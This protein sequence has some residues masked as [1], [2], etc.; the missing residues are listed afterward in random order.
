MVQAKLDTA[1]Q[2]ARSKQ[3][4]QQQP[5]P[6]RRPQTR[7]QHKLQPRPNNEKVI[8]SPSELK[9]YQLILD[10]F[11][12][13]FNDVL[14]D[15][16]F[17]PQLQTLKQ[18]LFDRDF[19]TAFTNTPS[20]LPIYSARWSPPRALAYSS[21][22]TSL[23][24]HLPKLY[25]STNN[26]PCLAIGGCSAELAAFA[27]ALTLLPSSPSGHITLLDSAPWAPVLDSLSNSLTTSPPISKYASKGTVHQP[28]FISLARLSYK[29]L[30][31]DA[32]ATPFSQLFTS[33]APQLVTL[34]FTLN[35]LFTSS[36]IGKT[37]SFLLNLSS[38][39]PIGS[40]LL[41]VDSPGSYSETTVGTSQK[42]Y[43]MAWLMDK[44]LSSVCPDVKPSETPE[45]RIKWKKLETHE[46]IWFRLPEELDYPIA[47]ENMRYQLHLYKAV[48]PAAPE[49]DH[50][51]DEDE[52]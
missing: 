33:D 48:D 30:E 42:K 5:K 9:H 25:S 7:E 38:A 10:I 37:T 17:E 40:L 26:L 47:L 19:A 41:V 35:E 36:G 20:N 52:D 49:V 28:A 24:P 46:S 22:F 45:G 6:K 27:S 29:F 23:S 39:I 12:R 1:P 34:F 18:S 13:T 44:I 15:A 4:Q 16:N 8:I 50:S 21:I 11:Q 51:E 43:P 14:R 32:L 2:K 31:Q 3:Q